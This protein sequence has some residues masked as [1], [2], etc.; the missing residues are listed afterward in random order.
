MKIKEWMKK[1]NLTVVRCAQRLGCS[2]STVNKI[3]NYFPARN[4]SYRIAWLVYMKSNQEI[5][6]SDMCGHAAWGK[7]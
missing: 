7:P 3:K 4:L 2:T 6:F 1:E 5:L